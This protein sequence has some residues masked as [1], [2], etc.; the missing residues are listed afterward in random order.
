MSAF[1]TPRRSCRTPLGVE[2]GYE[3]TYCGLGKTD[4]EDP[5]RTSMPRVPL[6]V[7]GDQLVTIGF[8]RTVR[9]S[10]LAVG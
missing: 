2:L 5:N 10:A 9:N 1:G 3:R 7:L 4:V 8:R 6:R